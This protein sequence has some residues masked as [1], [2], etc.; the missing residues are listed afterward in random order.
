[1]IEREMNAFIINIDTFSVKI[2]MK[3]GKL[4]FML[5]DRGSTPTLD[6]ASGY[7]KYIAGLAMRVALLRIGAVGKNVKHLILDEGFVACDSTNILKTKEIMELLMKIGEYN[8]IMMISHLENIRDI[9]DIRIDV[10][11]CAKNITSYI[12]FGAVRKQI[13][14][15]NDNKNDTVKA[16]PGRTRKI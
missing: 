1:M 7:Q 5:H 15:N 16:K 6:H 12:R 10:S 14:K 9:A 11:R 8:S 13:R 4:I 2:R 3:Y